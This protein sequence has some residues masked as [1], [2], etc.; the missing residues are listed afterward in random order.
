[1][2]VLAT[3]IT[4]PTKMLVDGASSNN[5]SSAT[6][7]TM[8]VGVTTTT[9][10]V[11]AVAAD[12]VAGKEG[13]RA[14]AAAAAAAPRSKPLSRL[15]LTLRRRLSWRRERSGLRHEKHTCLYRSGI[16]TLLTRGT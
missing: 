7:T 12:P 3:T 4:I 2:V 9:G 16:S 5:N 10:E 1:M 8:L 11:V 14:A 6:T 13:R 15:P